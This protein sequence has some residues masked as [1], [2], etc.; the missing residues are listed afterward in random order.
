MVLMGI[1]GLPGRPLQLGRFT[2]QAYGPQTPSP[3]TIKTHFSN[4]LSN[5]LKAPVDEANNL[6]LIEVFT[7]NP[8]ST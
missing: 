5:V 7:I 4:A 1:H 6:C 2:P 8:M 3:K